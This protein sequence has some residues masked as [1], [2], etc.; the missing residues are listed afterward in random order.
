MRRMKTS[1]SQP[2]YNPETGRFEAEARLLEDGQL[3]RYQLQVS[4]TPDAGFD[5]VMR[6]LTAQME[7][8]HR[9]APARA[10]R[11]SQ[12]PTRM[13][14]RGAAGLIARPFMPRGGASFAA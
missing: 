1:I 9:H 6:S 12:A 7:D 5:R 8:M 11:P 10:T 14:A 3:Y 13:A 2:R 4:A